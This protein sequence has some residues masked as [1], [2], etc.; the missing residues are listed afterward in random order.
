MP[1]LPRALLGLFVV[2][3]SGSAPPP[4]PAPATS[5][6]EQAQREDEAEDEV[7]A[8]AD[9][10]DEAPDG[11]ACD[12]GSDCA[13]GEH[14]RGP[15]GCNASWACGPAR[16]CGEER[17]G[18][19][20]CDGFTFYAPTNCPGR[21]YAHAGPCAALGELDEEPPEE[22]EGNTVCQS[23]DD[24][25]SGF[26]CAGSE[27]CS[28]LWTCVRRTRVRPRCTREVA[29]F[30]SCDGDSFEG[31]RTCPGRPYLHRGYCDGDEPTDVATAD[32]TADAGVV[33][34]DTG[35][36]P[37][38]RPDEGEGPRVCV[39]DRDCPRGLICTG[40]EGCTS[41]WYCARP[42]QRCIADTQYF[43]SCGGETF[44]ASMTCPGRPHRHRGACTPDERR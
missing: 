14:C 4:A 17:V 29:A 13:A 5:V 30:C 2:A 32:A 23:S 15:A 9:V 8:Y 33:A 36:A 16:E 35:V 24:C 27:G 37:P 39:R 10:E 12:H 11:A 42:R 28:T 7:A 31:A 20:G 6:V 21:P 18:W 26:V 43:C 40:T 3:C 19:C 34:R 25:P 1:K 22:V 41:D 44:T 38:R